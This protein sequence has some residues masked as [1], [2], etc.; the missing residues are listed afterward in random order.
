MPSASKSAIAPLYLLA[1][2]LMGGS[3]QGMWQNAL[4]QLAGLTIIA[5]TAIATGGEELSRSARV[6]LILAIA[7]VAWIALQAV[8]L[9]VAWLHHGSRG[10]IADGL[11]LLG[12]PV[13]S[14]PISVSPYSSLSALFCL[15]PPLGI[16]CAIVRLKAYRPSWLASALLA[17]AMAGTLLGALQVTNGSPSGSWYLYGETNIGVAVGF[18]ANAN[19]MA[20]LLVICLLFLAALGSD[21]PSRGRQR[22]W[23]LLAILGGIAT[24]MIAG[25]LLNGSLAGFALTL[26]VLLASP[27]ILLRPSGWLRRGLLLAAGA[28]LALS[29]GFIA[30]SSIGPAKIDLDARTSVA[31][32]AEILRKTGTAIADFMPLGS[33]LGTFVKVYPL[34]ESPD[35]VTNEYVVHAHNDY[36]EVALEL[37]IPGML[38]LLAFVGWWLTLI[39][40]AWVS[41]GGYAR[42]ASVASAAI[43]FHSLVDFPLRTAAMSAVF[44]MCLGLLV[45][46][47]RRPLPSTVSDLRPARHLVIG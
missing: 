37:G 11:A 41:G 40:P 33:G 20:M 42:A 43:L 21:E 5:W 26:P 44:A 9:P 28:L 6:P 10:R 8:P 16:Y 2:L 13:S 22:D 18:F 14:L 19:H 30:T 1:C 23:G 38:L 36:A 45:D 15:L 3:A 29:I 24:V 7:L 34:Y 47:P 32:R 46:R 25:I 31:S 35:S 27:A 4:L 17:G 12:R 39:G